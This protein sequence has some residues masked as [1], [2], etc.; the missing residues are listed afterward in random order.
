M[1]NPVNH[2][3][4]VSST[5]TLAENISSS[6]LSFDVSDAS[7]FPSTPFRIEI[8]SEVMKVA[9]VASNTL[10]VTRGDAGTSA[11][12]HTSGAAVRHVVVAQDLHLNLGDHEDTSL[13][14]PA[15]GDMIY[16]NDSSQWVKVGGTKTDGNVPTVQS[17]GTIAW[18]AHAF[19][20]YMPIDVPPATPNAMDDEFD[21]SSLDA[22]WS[23]TTG[24]TN[25]AWSLSSGLLVADVSANKAG[26]LV[27]TIPSG[28]WTIAAQLGPFTAR[29]SGDNHVPNG[30]TLDEGSSTQKSFRFVR[31]LKNSGLKMLL[32]NLPSYTDWTSD[33][34]EHSIPYSGFMYQRIR[35]SG[36]TYYFEYS[37][38]GF[39]WTSLWS[40]TL[41]FTPTKIGITSAGSNS[42]PIGGTFGW[43]RRTA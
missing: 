40:G 31:M 39:M 3:N 33:V 4:T 2:S 36:S 17:D 19:D 30:M 16:R 5:I 27:Q 7:S 6:D 11:A 12:S 34:A 13:S 24:G 41:S 32:M 1:A 18:E 28:D 21:G 15:V 10:T 37:G 35:R 23:Q 26:S 8:D 22:K 14:S 25:P 29:I 9:G 43:F 38:D 20:L 42:V